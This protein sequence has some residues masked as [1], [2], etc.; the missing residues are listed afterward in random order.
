MGLLVLLEVAAG[1]V[2]TTVLHHAT[3]LMTAR[4]HHPTVHPRVLVPAVVVLV[5]LVA[6][7]PITSTAEEED[8][9][10]RQGLRDWDKAERESRREGLKSELAERHL[11]SLTGEV[12]VSGAA[13]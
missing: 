12:G 2:A 10:K 6:H 9:V 3:H 11:D 7:L 5:V 13:F 8:K 4:L 1:E